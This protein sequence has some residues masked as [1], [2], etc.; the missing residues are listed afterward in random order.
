M[1]SADG[2]LRTRIHDALR[3]IARHA[4]DGTVS[5]TGLA[6]QLDTDGERV[7]TLLVDFVKDGLLRP[8]YIERCEVGHVSS[9]IIGPNGDPEEANCAYCGRSVQHVQYTVYRFTEKLLENLA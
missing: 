8:E 3:A 1:I 5:A 4:R 2:V 7:A 9:H 6:Q